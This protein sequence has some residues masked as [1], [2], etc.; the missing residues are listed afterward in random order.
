MFDYRQFKASEGSH[1]PVLIKVLSISDGPV[2]E[3]GTGTNS[4]SVL[5]WLCNATKRKIDS[6][7][8]QKEWYFLARNYRNEFHGVH[9][10]DNWDNLDVNQ[11]W[12]VI[13]IDHWPGVRRNVE[14][15][16]L[17]NSGDYIIVHDTEAK[18]DWH[19][20]FSRAFPLYKYRFDYK[21]AYPETSV[22]S[23]FIDV[24]KLVI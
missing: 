5:H 10:I 9:F 18:S 3:L 11:H 6:Y 23:N 7:E 8:S 15:A 1:I 24:T 21:L 20:N 13:F 14:M 19:Y 12:S 17:C 16:R 4:T 22:L 2:L